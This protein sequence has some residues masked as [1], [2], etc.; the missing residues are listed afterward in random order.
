MGVHDFTS[1]AIL[2]RH[3]NLHAITRPLHSGEKNQRDKSHDEEGDN[4]A[5]LQGATSV[6]KLPMLRNFS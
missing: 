1:L 3:A 5:N 2:E 6:K 4:Q